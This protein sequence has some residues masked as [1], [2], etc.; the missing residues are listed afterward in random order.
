M[1]LVLLISLLRQVVCSS[2]LRHCSEIAVDCEGDLGNPAVLCLVQIGAVIP[3]ELGGSGTEGA[4]FLFDVVAPAPVERAGILAVLAS[5]MND[6][7]KT[8]VFHDCRCD[9]VVLAQTLHIDK[10]HPVL[11]TQILFALAGKLA[12]FVDSAES[13]R[14]YDC[15]HRISLQVLLTRF[16]FPPVPHKVGLGY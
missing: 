15:T 6:G 4:V 2:L 3:P 9:T 13:R 16:G 1:S 8:K 5:L 10:V 11:D 14:L 7:S 12:L